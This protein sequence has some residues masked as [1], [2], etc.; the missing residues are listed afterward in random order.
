MSRERLTGLNNKIKLSKF[1]TLP[2]IAMRMG[3]NGMVSQIDQPLIPKAVQTGFK[4]R[5]RKMDENPTTSSSSSTSS[6]TSFIELIDE[7]LEDVGR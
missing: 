3:E 1:A 7:E 5:M 2:H 6:S 4:W